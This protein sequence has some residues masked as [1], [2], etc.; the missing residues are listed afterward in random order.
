MPGE[1]TEQKF[2]VNDKK[3]MLVLVRYKPAGA[4]GADDMLGG[5]TSKVQSVVDTVENA[6]NS[7]PGLNL[8]FKEEKE[9]EKKCDKEYT[10]YKDYK[11]W[12]SYMKKMKDE[13]CNKLNPDN[14]TIVFDFDASDAGD[15]EKEGKKLANQIKSKISAWKDYTACF[16][17]VGLGQG[18][19]VANE[20]IKELI[21]EE[22]FKKKWWVQSVIYVATPLYKNQHTFDEKA[23]FKGK[24]K[25]ISFGNTFDL[26]HQAIEYFEPNGELLKMIAESNS[27]TIS[28]FTGKIKAQLVTTLARLLSIKGF[29]AGTSKAEEGYDLKENIDKITQLKDD[30][31]GLIEE[32][33]TAVKNILEAAPG[34]IKLGDLPNFSK[35]TSGFNSIPSQCMQ[36]FDDFFNNLKNKTKEGIEHTSLDSSKIGL[37]SF[38]NILCPLVDKIT[39]SLKVLSMQNTDSEVMMKNIFDKA[40]IKKILAP[41]GKGFT[42]IPADP[43]IEEVIKSVKAAEE[44]QKVQKENED[45]TT[46]KTT[47]QVFMDQAS[48][49]VNTVKSKIAGVVKNEDLEV[50]KADTKTKL[51]ISDALT[52]MVLPMFPNK[53]KFYGTILQWL[54]LNGL[55]G[56]LNKITAD[57]ALAPLKNLVGKFIGDFDEGTPEKPGL[58][59]SLQNLDKELNRI[60]GFFNKNNYPVSKEANS[61]YFIYNSHNIILKKPYGQILNAIDRETGYL[62]VMQSNGYTNNFNLDKNDYQGGGA[63]NDNVQPAKVLQEKETSNT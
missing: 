19:N 29:S 26:T 36:R 57:A 53:G 51:L 10:Y 49:M 60:K 6:A 30:V 21:N 46:D 45:T 37:N 56:F 52:A 35:I 14:E 11:D 8:F 47:E 50:S 5:I 9:P 41:A 34:I 43:Y 33:I 13:L 12:D 58:K 61:L 22:D 16:H 23:A 44:K 24:G 63:Q 40:G 2:E 25:T 18:G 20:C 59:I 17:F 27:N 32:L 3:Q 48:V 28:V 15:R 62:D 38:F 7:I 1:Q 31:K 39:D 55:N 4:M 54:P 42:N